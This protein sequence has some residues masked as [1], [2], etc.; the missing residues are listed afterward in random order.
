MTQ[1]F[2]LNNIYNAQYVSKLNT[3]PKL[4]V[5]TH[6]SMIDSLKDNTWEDIWPTLWDDP[7]QESKSKNDPDA[8]PPRICEREFES[9]SS[10]RVNVCEGW[11]IITCEGDHP[12]H[13][14][15][16]NALGLEPWRENERIMP[17]APDPDRPLLHPPFHFQIQNLSW[18][19]NP[20]ILSFEEKS[21]RLRPKLFYQNYCLLPSSKNWGVKVVSKLPI[22]SH[23][24]SYQNNY[25]NNS[26]DW[27]S[28][29]L[30]STQR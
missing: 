6:E 19:V 7:W 15:P 8:P 26:K 28:F 21:V 20:R 4:S 3:C 14:S 13:H 9:F 25:I 29:K 23:F 11:G 1:K 17:A 2:G 22:T 5:K 24:T 12:E 16:S 30:A 27:D 10:L 18:L